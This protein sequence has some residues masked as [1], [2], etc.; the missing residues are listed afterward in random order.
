MSEFPVEYPNH[1]DGDDTV[2]NA[3]V[4]ILARKMWEEQPAFRNAVVGGFEDF[5]LG[6]LPDLTLPDAVD[7]MLRAFWR[8]L[9]EPLRD[10][11]FLE[12]ASLMRARTCP[13]EIQI[14]TRAELAAQI[15]AAV[16]SIIKRKA[17]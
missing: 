14:A 17:K 2:I 15:E 5:P 3:Q 4:E 10:H 13:E 12:A 1:E 16:K 11:D 8:E 7:L 9:R 6:G